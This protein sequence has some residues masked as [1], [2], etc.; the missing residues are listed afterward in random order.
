MAEAKKVTKP[1]KIKSQ[2]ASKSTVK[3]TKTAQSSQA[4]PV[5][6]PDHEPDEITFKP[7]AKDRP[8][9]DD[10]RNHRRLRR[11]KRINEIDG[12]SCVEPKAAFYAFPKI[13]CADD[14]QW[15]LDLLH[16]E[17]VLVVHG[18]GFGEAGRGHIRIVYLPPIEVLS[19]AFDRI[20]RF[21][22]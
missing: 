12:M 10:Y 9:A 11:M 1:R 2:P 4:S 16:K 8:S 18:S 22:K 21:M 19:E 20:E 7:P 14:K 15:A 3:E 13:D 6:R 5:S 17:K